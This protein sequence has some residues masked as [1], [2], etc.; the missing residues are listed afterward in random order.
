MRRCPD[1]AKLRGLGFKPKVSFAAGL[2]KTFDWYV[3]NAS[4]YPQ[5]AAKK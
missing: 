1:V 5:A 4:L 2:K 3:A